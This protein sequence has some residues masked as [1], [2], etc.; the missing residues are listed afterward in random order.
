MN[1]LDRLVTR[2]RRRALLRRAAVA[3]ASAVASAS[4][5]MVVALV[6]DA[7]FQLGYGARRGV[8]YGIAGLVGVILVAGIARRRRRRERVLRDVEVAVGLEH[9]ALVIADQLARRGPDRVDGVGA[10]SRRMLAE[11]AEALADGVRARAVVGGVFEGGVLRVCGGVLVAVVGFG[12]A[13]SRLVGMTAVRFV[14]PGGGHPPYCA[15][16]YA[17]TT[18]PGSPRVGMP[19][20]VVVEAGLVTPRDVVV[21]VESAAGRT[22]LPTVRRSGAG[23]VRSEGGGGVS[24]GGW[25][26]EIGRG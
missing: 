4:A 6:V 20:R 7:Q 17:I 9:G 12:L 14:E 23:V 2:V 11:R 24:G 16:A 3:C 21:E 8:S 15:T 18:V 13:E 22:V 1:G 10:R 5:V 19:V 25:V 26:A